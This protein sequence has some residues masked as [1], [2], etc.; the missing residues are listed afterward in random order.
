MKKHWIAAALAVSV[1]GFAVADGGPGCGVGSMIFK[2]QSGVGP[3][4][5]AATTNGT[6]G[7][8]TFGMTTGTLGCNANQPV[9]SMASVFVDENMEKVA[10]D[11]SRGSG[12]H[13]ETL[14]TLMNI[15]GAD[16][17]LFKQTVQTNFDQ[18]YTS[19]EITSSEVISNLAEIMGQDQSLAKYLG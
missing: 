7:N 1:S 3:H 18:I 6:L 2:G 15:E 5:L 8:Q 9:T 14:A 16:R 10:R 13:I 11:M 17:D 12:E 19:D 4:V